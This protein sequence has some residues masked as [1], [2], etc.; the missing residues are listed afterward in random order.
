MSHLGDDLNGRIFFETN[1]L[2]PTGEPGPEPAEASQLPPDGLDSLQ[3]YP[4][5]QVS[6][7]I[8]CCL[9]IGG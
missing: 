7:A 9:L 4:W 6:A 1:L 8:K 2:R 3:L 5:H